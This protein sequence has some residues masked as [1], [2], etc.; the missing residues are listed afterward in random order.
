MLRELQTRL[1]PI[2]LRQRFDRT[3]RWSTVGFMAGALLG[4]IWYLAFWLGAAI[5]PEFA[6]ILLLVCGIVSA[7]VGFCWS[8]SWQT[9]ARLVDGAYDLKDRT[10][11]ALDFAARE[12][13]D[14]VQELQMQDAVQHLLSIDAT[15]VVP[16]KTPRYTLLAI[17][18][19]A[20]ML[21]LGFLPNSRRSSVANAPTQ[22]LEVVLDQAA[23]LEAT[24]LNDLDEAAKTGD[25][26]NLNDLAEEMRQAIKDLKEPRV[27]QRD[28][29]AKLSEMQAVVAAAV[30]QLDVQQI[31]SQLQDLAAALQVSTA[32]EA[33]SQALQAQNYEQAA[34][35]LEKIEV[36]SMS[37]K[38]RDAAAANL[39][40]LSEKLGKGKKGKLSDAVS[41]MTDGFTNE[42]DT[43]AKDG[44]CQ[45]A[46]ECRKQATKKK[47]SECLACQLNRVSSCKSCCQGQCNTPGTKVAKTDKPSTNYGLGASNQPTGDDNTKLDSNRRSEEL[48]GVSGEGPSER[49]T[50]TTAEARQDAARNYRERYPEYRKQMEEV[51]DSEPLPLGHRATVR[52]YFEAIR[53]TSDESDVIEKQ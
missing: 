10:V 52:K 45:A 51:L 16:W 24:M 44:L 9:S 18:S 28:A 29:L 38:E 11:T 32:T 47:V 27:D 37:K 34:S 19:M 48:I 5:E 20:M 36:S 42:N 1:S 2:R 33:A 15:R 13:A 23:Q 6:W 30:K 3:W 53:P 8:T 22:P 50:M 41:E 7:L 31:D 49:E 25:D 39:A 4:S 43:Q 26:P 35:E 14:P 12:S 21:V 46:G 17:A 40:K